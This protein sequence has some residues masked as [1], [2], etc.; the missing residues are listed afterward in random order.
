[1]YNPLVTVAEPA[2]KDIFADARKS[3]PDLLMFDPR[4]SALRRV[5][6]SG[7]VMHQREGQYYAMDGTNGFRF[8]PTKAVDFA[9]GELV[10]VAGFPS[11]TGPSPVLQEAVVRK[12]GVAPLRDARP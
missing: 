4:S 2:P 11:L 12:V 9:V 10:E 8:I 5:K 1:M 3:V 6:V 7:Q